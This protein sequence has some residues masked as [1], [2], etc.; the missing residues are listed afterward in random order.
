M[1]VIV[2]GGIVKKDDKYLLIQEAKE[3]CRGKWNIPAGRLETNETITYGAKREIREECGY[4]VA[5]TGVALIGDRVMGENSISY[6]IFSTNIIDG[7]IK[8]N[9]EEILD[10]KWF[11]YEEIIGMEAELRSPDLIITAITTVEK[12]K[13]SDANI[14]KQF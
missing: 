8:F 4:N 10:A 11:T 5:I 3:K 12:R 13:T 2:V 6:I 14:V 9:R 1:S 7:D